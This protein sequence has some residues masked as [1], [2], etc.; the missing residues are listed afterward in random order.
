VRRWRKNVE[1]EY[2]VNTVY[3]VC[4]WKKLYLLKLFQEHREREIKENDG[5][6]G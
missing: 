6:R 1:G 3:H 4:R 2:S 5:W